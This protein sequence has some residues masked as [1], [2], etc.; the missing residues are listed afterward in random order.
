MKRNPE[1]YAKA[2]L[3]INLLSASTYQSAFANP[4]IL[5]MNPAYVFP[6]SFTFA[7]LM[8]NVVESN[9]GLATAAVIEFI[10]GIFSST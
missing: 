9:P 10:C 4:A 6:N 3:T 2:S 7:T 1:S 8:S 5:D